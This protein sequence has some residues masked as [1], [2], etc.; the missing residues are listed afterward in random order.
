M[1]SSEPITAICTCCER[2]WDPDKRDP[3]CPECGNDGD[4]EGH[5]YRFNDSNDDEQEDA[6]V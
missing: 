4:I 6:H 1:T 3:V 5:A 2:E